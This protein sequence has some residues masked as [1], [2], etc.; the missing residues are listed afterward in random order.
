MGVNKFNMKKIT[1]KSKIDEYGLC[2]NEYENNFNNAKIYFD[3]ATGKSPEMEVSKAIA[4]ILKPKIKSGSKLLDVGC[5]CGH[6]YRSIKKIVKK[7]FFYTGTDPYE[8][9]LDKAKIAWRNDA[10]VNFL[11]GNIYKLPF[12]KNQFDLTICSNVFIHL[13]KIKKPLQELLRVTK[14]TIII[15]TVVYDVSYKVQLVYNNKWWKNTDVKPK[16]EFDKNGNP[17]AFSYFNIL[18]KDFLEGTIKDINKKA[19]V[20]FIKD[21]FFSKK[22][23][24]SSNKKEKRPLATRI[25]GDEQFS[26]CLMQPHYFVIIKNN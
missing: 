22:K 15:R 10:N 7:N 8:I 25:V 17:R 2:L 13:N 4:N 16:D 12:K 5:A 24:S 1:K 23:I 9:F 6:Y 11:K 21:N 19:K 20:T 14:G 3:R 18:S 26:G